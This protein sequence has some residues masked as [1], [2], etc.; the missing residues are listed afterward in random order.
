V[1]VA[2]ASSL[3]AAF[4]APLIGTV[5]RNG[6]PPSTRK[7]S[8]WTAS[9]WYSQWN[10]RAS[11]IDVVSCS[12]SGA[13]SR[14]FAMTTFGDADAQ[15]R[16]LELGARAGQVDGVGAGSL[17][18]PFRLAPRLLR[19][20]EVDLARHVGRLGHHD[21]AVG[22]DL[23]EPADD[24]ERL[25]AAALADAQLPDAEHRDERRMVRQ[26]PELALR[27]GQLDRIDRVRVGQA[28]RRDDLEHQR[29]GP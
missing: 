3:R 11:L 1:R 20:L 6:R 19:P 23:E 8:C 2:A 12:P 15:Q 21:D 18:R 22:P 5:P 25:L 27:A 14:P 7:T 4:L 17:E 16:L 13:M 28:F 24:R 26:H 10:G 9:G 29:H